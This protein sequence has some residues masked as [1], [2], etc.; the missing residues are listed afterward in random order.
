MIKPSTA[1]DSRNQNPAVNVRFAKSPTAMTKNELVEELVKHRE[2]EHDLETDKTES[3]ILLHD[4]EVHQ[5]EL[6]LQNRELQDSHQLLE[7]SRNKY[8][9]LYDFAPMGYVTLDRHGVILE[10]NLMA[11]SM[12]QTER[13]KL[14]G[15]PLNLWIAHEEQRIFLEHLRKTNSD[16]DS[17]R[18]TCELQL[19][20]TRDGVPIWVELHSLSAVDFTSGEEVLRTAVLDVGERKRAELAEATSR[21]LREER[22]LREAF[23][24]TLAHDL[25]TPLASARMG[26]QLLARHSLDPQT[27]QTLTSRIVQNV[28]RADRMVQDLLDANRIRAGERL[29]IE[30]G[31]YCLNEIVQAS[32]D[33]MVATYGN[34]FV[35]RADKSVLG[36]WCRKS[37]IRV[38]ENLSSNA[39]KYGQADSPVTISILERDGRAILSVHN[40]G[41]P[42][43]PQDQKTLF[44]PFKRSAAAQSGHQPGWG[45]GLTLVRGLIEAHQGSIHLQSAHGEGTTFTVDLPLDART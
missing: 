42:I 39:I 32:V 4:L 16:R 31:D 29:P 19:R 14:L 11:A 24:S 3:E 40:H 38:I 15:R 18:A 5:I 20:A 30:I 25:R 37:L 7:D 36:Y 8:V 45:L 26:A 9:D 44:K 41:N 12:L 13:A 6:E 34:R 10:I 43:R 35:I 33:E 2:A 27:V 23:V 28:D 17:E 1:S 21:T 22:K